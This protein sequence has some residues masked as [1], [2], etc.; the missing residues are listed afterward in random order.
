MKY[1]Q[2]TKRIKL[3]K[4]LFASSILW[5]L[6]DGDMV[7]VNKII[8]AYLSSLNQ[9][10]AKILI[11][12]FGEERVHFIISK[13]QKHIHQDD[14]QEAMEQID[15]ALD[16]VAY[17]QKATPKS[18][19]Q[20]INKPKQRDIDTLLLTMSKEEILDIAQQQGLTNTRMFYLNQLLNLSSS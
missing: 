19:D 1:S 16:P 3:N 11:E 2:K 10:D 15:Y 17:R 6:Q 4:K 14:Y 7:S 8:A 5:S 13:L 12:L 18:I 20:I 9:Q